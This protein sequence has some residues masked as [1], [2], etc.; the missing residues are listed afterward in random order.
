MRTLRAGL[1]TLGAVFL[2]TAPG[3]W[4]DMTQQ[5]QELIRELVAASGGTIPTERVTAMLL[6]Q[7]EQALGTWIERLVSDEPD[8]A[9]D[10]KKAIREHLGDF[11]WFSQTFSTR[12]SEQID[13]IAIREQAYFPLYDR[14]FEES[15]LKEILAFYRTPTGKK[16]VSVLPSIIQEGMEATQPLLQMQVA[17]L[18]GE[19][20][21]ERRA[22]IE[23]AP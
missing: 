3:A 4:A 7:F 20:L 5:K 2:T 19:I 14:Y 13:L 11:D 9:S 1:A 12:F 21:R 15:E 6:L 23:P 17:E 18:V 16:S 10:E 8:L 22:E